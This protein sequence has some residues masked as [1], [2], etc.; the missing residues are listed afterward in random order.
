MKNNDG[1]SKCFGFVNFEN[2]E[3]AAR[4]VKSLNG[5]TFGKT[6][7]YVGRYQNKHQRQLELKHHL[8]F[9]KNAF[10]N[11]SN[12]YVKNL[13][14][15]IDDEKLKELFSEF[16]SVMSCKVLRDEK[17]NSRNIGY[18]AFSSVKEASD[19]L[20][21]MNGK[22]LVDKPLCIAIAQRKEDRRAPLQNLGKE[23][24]HKAPSETFSSGGDSHSCIITK[25]DASAHSIDYGSVQ[26]F[27]EVTG[28]EA[29]GE[30]DSIIEKLSNVTMKLNGLVGELNGIVRE[31]NGLL[32][33]G[34]QVHME[35]SLTKQMELLVDKANSTIVFV[36]NFG[37]S[38]TEE[39]LKKTFGKL[40]SVTDAGVMRN[41]DGASKSFGFVKFKNAQDA[42]RAVQSLNG[43]RFD[44]KK[45]N[46]GTAQTGD[47]VDKQYNLYVKNLNDGISDEKKLKELF[48]SFGLVTS[49]K[50]NRNRE[51][52]SKGS[53]FVAFSS[54]EEAF[55][56]QCEMNGKIIFGKP[57]KVALAQRKTDR[58]AQLQNLD[59]ETD[60]KALPKTFLYSGR[61]MGF[62]S[63]HPGEESL[64]EGTE[65][66][67]DMLLNGK[68]VR[69]GSSHDG[70]ERR[71]PMDKPYF[72]NVIIKNFCKSTTEDDL[73]KIFSD[74]GVVTRTIIMRNK[75]QTSNCIGYVDFENADDAARAVESLNG[76]IFNKKT[77]YVGI[78]QRRFQGE[79]RLNHQF[80]SCV[81]EDYDR[82]SN[83]CVENLDNSIADGKLSEVFSP[84]RSLKSR[85]VMQDQ[86]KICEERGPFA[87]SSPEK[88]SES[89]SE[90]NRKQIYSKTFHAACV[91][92][93]EDR[94]AWLQGRPGY[95]CK[96]LLVPGV[97]QARPLMHSMSIPLIQ[98]HQKDSH[99]RSRHAP[100]QKGLLPAV[101]TKHQMLRRGNNHHF[102]RENMFSIWYDMGRSPVCDTVI[103]QSKPL[104]AWPSSIANV[105]S[106]NRRQCSVRFF[107][108]ILR[109][110]QQLI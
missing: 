29:I 58:T 81:N 97:L 30:H 72:T 31:L 22:V 10:D 75:E 9:V 36:K 12:L 40:G 92:R 80:D 68:Q 24:G 50:V 106:L 49:C 88:A 52:I 62:G 60:H 79:L 86:N 71:L 63:V 91:Q 43:Q 55:K 15:S 3:D 19:A 65:E 37:Q 82:G 74:F 85:E 77:W 103:S 104:G 83:L 33:N 8:E 90:K 51:G 102:H 89:L 46:S 84:F 27:G 39:D 13:D 14:C 76:H 44:E 105:A 69:M 61:S 38:T 54:P 2:A 47:S 28:Q 48:S 96:E 100:M 6:K 34:K 87:L 1:I 18:V 5:Q 4:A 93:K 21:G 35:S 23:N 20:S 56:A 32:L 107:T 57:L 45:W 16:G 99:P 67:N 94:G 70:K 98:N 110:C 17:G 53:G 101:A 95:R 78:A 73:K 109:R 66:H 26:V 41:E 42:A 7:W 64:R 59:E 25:E 108:C 11:G